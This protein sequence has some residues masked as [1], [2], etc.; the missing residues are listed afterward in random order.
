MA[1]TYSW[2][3]DSMEVIPSVDGLTNVVS[4][5]NWS[6][7]GVSSIG[8]NGKISS[9]SVVPLPSSENFTPYD[10]LTQD[11]VISWLES[12]LNISNLQSR[13]DTQ[14]NLIEN[15]PTVNIPLPWDVL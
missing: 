4:I 2:V 10:E 13:I 14:I 3:I 9:T 6:Y 1:N 11:T 8:T 5:I 15:P 7:N 12:V